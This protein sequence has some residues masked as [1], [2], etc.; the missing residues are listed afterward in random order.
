MKKGPKS[1]KSE[2]THQVSFANENK[3]ILDTS[4][5]SIDIPYSDAFVIQ[6]LWTIQNEGKGFKS[7]YYDYY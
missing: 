3:I 4:N 7:Y 6:S 5:R 1:A 2:Q